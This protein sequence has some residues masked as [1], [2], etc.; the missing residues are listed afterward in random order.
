MTRNHSPD[1]SPGS[2]DPRVLLTGTEHTPASC[3][4]QPLQGGRCTVF[5][6]SLRQGWL[7][8]PIL[9]GERA[10]LLLP[11]VQVCLHM[12]FI[13]AKLTKGLHPL[14]RVCG[15]A[16]ISPTHCQLMTLVLGTCGITISGTSIRFPIL[17]MAGQCSVF[18]VQHFVLEVLCPTNSWTCTLPPS[19]PILP[20]LSDPM[21]LEATHPDPGTQLPSNKD[22]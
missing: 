7:V 13:L 16:C 21:G 2:Q 12:D 5:P 20:V 17:C 18:L 8:L 1:P 6:L 4:L 3:H 15:W 22:H 10:D 19:L 9:L 11:G 14:P